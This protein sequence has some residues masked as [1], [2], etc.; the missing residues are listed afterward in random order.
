[1][2]QWFASGYG[3]LDIAA[4]GEHGYDI[5]VMPIQPG[6]PVLLFGEGAKVWRHMARG[7]AP[8]PAES[9]SVEVM[10]ELAEMGLAVEDPAHAARISDLPRPWLSSFTHELVYALLQRV[11]TSAGVELVFIK[12]PTLHAQGLRDREH[13]GDVDCWVRPGDDLR[14]ADAMRAWGWTPL[15]LPFTGTTVS[16]SL[17]LVA[18]EWGC[19]I[20][21]HTSFPGMRLRPGEA[22]DVLIDDAEARAFAGVPV[23]TPSRETHAV[24]SALHDMRPYNGAAAPEYAVTKAT[25]VLRT[26]GRG[27]I[28][29]VDR[30]DAGF[31]LRAPLERAFGE[32]APDYSRAL[33]PADWS[34]RLEEAT[35]LRHF[36]ALRF[37]PIQ[38]RLRALIRLMWPT[39]ETMRIALEEPQATGRRIF[40]AR[41]RRVRDSVRKLAA[42]R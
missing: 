22:F 16:H 31:V 39:A 38:H 7:D 37:V 20:D 15:I 34:M 33:P 11:A 35:S 3:A 27:V 21:V 18:G 42:R 2:T 10:K 6:H 9:E 24:L 36:K 23:L 8:T 25:A 30:F 17:T 5:A 12:G 26:V 32:D 14:L 40:L 13:S 19:A 4:T 1:M 29:I 41:V 28:P